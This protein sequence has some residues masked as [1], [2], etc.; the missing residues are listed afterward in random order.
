MEDFKAQETSGQF[1]FNTVYAPT[2]PTSEFCK[3]TE[4]VT[5]QLGQAATETRA[6]SDRA[7]SP[8]R[9]DAHG[10]QHQTV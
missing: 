9:A 1:T 5:S 4:T 3:A 8:S 6:A 10:E 7:P 2:F